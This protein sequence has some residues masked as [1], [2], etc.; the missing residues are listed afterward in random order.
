MEKVQKKLIIFMPSMDGGGVEKNLIII[1]NFLSKHV[2]NLI[3][4]TFDDRFNNKFKKKI[5]IINFK[6][7][8]IKNFLSILNILFVYLFY[9]KKY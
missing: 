5:K 1:S 6:K 3:L 9:L 2:K 7:K 4:I 8:Q